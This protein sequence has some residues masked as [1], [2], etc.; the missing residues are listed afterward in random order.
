[1]ARIQQLQPGQINPQAQ[2]VSTFVQPGRK[3]TIKVAKPEQ[4]PQ[5]GQINAVGTSGV[6]QV[7]GE[8]SFKRLADELKVF[9]PRLMDTAEA[10]GL[11]YVDWRMDVGEAQAMEQVQR[12]LAQIDEQAEVSADQRAADNRRLSAINPQAGWL[13][14]TL[15]PYQQMGFER[16]KVKMA[17]QQVGLGLASY[18]QQKSGQIDPN[19]GRPY[20]DY[21]APD[22]GMSGVQKLQAEYQLDLEAKYGIDSSSPGYQKYFA[23]NLLRAQGQV[24][25][26]VLDDRTTYFESKIGPQAITGTQQA[27][28]E[29][30]TRLEPIMTSDGSMVPYLIQMPDGG[31][32]VN[33]GW[34][35]S[36]AW[37]VG[38]KFKELI[39][40]APLGMSAEIAEN[41]YK[42]L[43]S[44]Y[45]EGS[46]QRRILDTMR[47]PDGVAFGN[48]FGY[49][50]R[51]ATLTFTKDQ[52]QLQTNADKLL[53]RRFEDT[54]R[55]QLNAGVDANTAADLAIQSINAGRQDA[56]QPPLSQA[57]ESRLRANGIRQLG[58]ISP[59]AAGPGQGQVIP[60]DPREATALVTQ[61]QTQD[62]FDI[63]VQSA[64]A[65]LAAIRPSLPP[66]RQ[67]DY[68]RAVSRIDAAAKAQADR[69]E[70]VP[71]YGTV[72]GQRIST[73]LGEDEIYL[74]GA[75]LSTATDLITG[76]AQK[77]MTAKL[78]ALSAETEG[79]I[80]QAQV[81]DVFREVWPVLQKE[82]LDGTFAIP[83][84]KGYG[85]E[86]ET[87]PRPLVDTES[88][89]P[90]PLTGY[91][92]NQ[93][94]SMP[95]RSI[96][97]RNYKDPQQGPV[98]SA[99]ALISVI[100][101]AASGG[102]EN[103]AFTK[104]WRQ[105]KAPNAWS[106][107]QSQLRFYPRLGNG[108]G[109]TNEQLQRAKQDLLSFAVRDSNRYSTAQMLRYSPAL[110]RLNNWANEIA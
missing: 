104:A 30:A 105:A 98:L 75:D 34:I 83:G 109:W 85:S 110:A 57:Q 84:H 55:L 82:V 54:F 1:M 108:K 79:S 10:A 48:R 41:L 73:L 76:E 94:N 93:L 45:P 46:L 87:G 44:Q 89:G 80:T 86:N 39:A 20:V 38:E 70:W 19:T 71:K 17:G 50:A 59:Q 64:R 18:V 28:V 60:V 37:Q 103:A 16:G 35:K 4:L 5:V 7:A 106:F 68:D 81:D 13:M 72:L 9:N 67:G 40:R 2:P 22:L 12:G 21:E 77:R 61:L 25:N 58:E 96:A 32:S 91:D 88:K 90:A 97:L 107:I 56:G 99:A 102:K 42:S 100:T 65:R 6:G 24:A 63:D 3:D 78:Q 29:A 43:A 14:R 23:P 33:P 66:D 74:Q 51:E 101:T 8:N 95:R 69:S 92:L 15:D 26:Q 52:A 36:R 47:G 49:L 31:V 11:K 53:D 62:L 27:L